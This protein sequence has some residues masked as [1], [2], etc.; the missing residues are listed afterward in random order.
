VKL[1]ENT[2]KSGGTRE[3]ILAEYGLKTGGTREQILAEYGSETGRN[4]NLR[5]VRRSQLSKAWIFRDLVAM[6]RLH[7]KI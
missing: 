7:K 3:Q 2:A 1:L 4:L 5:I 6:L